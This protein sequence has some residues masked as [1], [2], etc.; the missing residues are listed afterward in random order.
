MTVKVKRWKSECKK[1]K[2]NR[3]TMLWESIDIHIR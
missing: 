1:V 2:T 3:R